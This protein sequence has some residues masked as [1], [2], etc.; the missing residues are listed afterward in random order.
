MSVEATDS[1]LK[2]LIIAQDELAFQQEVQIKALRQSEQIGLIPFT[3]TATNA[4]N[5][6][7]KC[8]SV[9]SERAARG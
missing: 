8:D 4:V 2:N 5:S 6:F 3:T 7:S 1:Q 9:Q